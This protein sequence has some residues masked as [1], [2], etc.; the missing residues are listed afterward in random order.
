MTG[1]AK[2]GFTLIEMLVVLIIIGI[3]TTITLALMG[4]L[5]EG[6]SLTTSVQLLRETFSEARGLA[7]STNKTY[8]IRIEDETIDNIKR[9]KLTIYSDTDKDGLFTAASD[10][11]IDS[12]PTELMNFVVFEKAP[13]WIGFAPSGDTVFPSGVS[14][15]GADEYD[16]MFSKG[17]PVGDIVLGV[18]QQSYKMYIDVDTFGKV[19]ESHFWDSSAK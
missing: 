4:V 8:F 19:R 7:T 2:K 3:M 1:N 17:T 5:S 13:Q 18:E 14:D 16:S 15:I 9:G 10:T 6:S 12:R 11:P